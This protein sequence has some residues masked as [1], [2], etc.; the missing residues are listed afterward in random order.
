[1]CGKN[2]T[3]IA[4]LSEYLMIFPEEKEVVHYLLVSVIIQERNTMG[5]GNY[6]EEYL[7]STTGYGGSVMTKL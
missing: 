1:M 2:R 5:S 3:G 7:I 6:F 4:L